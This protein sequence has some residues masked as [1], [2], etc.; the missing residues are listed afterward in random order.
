MFC[1]LVAVGKDM[2]CQLVAVGR[3]MFCQLVAVEALLLLNQ[4][5]FIPHQF[6]VI[7]RP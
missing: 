7:F 3:D 2:F 1:Q 6:I 4:E 5:W